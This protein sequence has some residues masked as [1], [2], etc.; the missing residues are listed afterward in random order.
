MEGKRN[1]HLLRVKAA[2]M[3]DSRLAGSTDWPLG[4]KM[5]KRDALWVR[6]ARDEWTRRRALK[7]E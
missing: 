4:H 3:S 5:T 1:L 7:G 6:V 2:R